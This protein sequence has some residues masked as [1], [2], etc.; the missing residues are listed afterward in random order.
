MIGWQEPLMTIKKNDL[1][2]FVKVKALLFFIQYGHANF[3]WVL[4]QKII[5]YVEKSLIVH[6]KLSSSEDFVFLYFI[7]QSPKWPQST[8]L[9]NQRSKTNIYIPT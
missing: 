2:S 3:I 5:L 4:Q 8:Q 6:I 9:I 1:P 7:Y